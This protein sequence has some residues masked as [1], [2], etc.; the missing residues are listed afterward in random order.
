MRKAFICPTKY[1]QGQDELLNLGYFIK[2]FG[3]SALLIA[4]KDDIERVKDKLDSTA[5]KF[6]VTFVESNFKGECSREEVARLQE[7]AKKNKC[8][9]TIG[10]GGGKA[11]DTAKCV[12]QGNNLIIVPT[13]AATDAPTSHSAVLYTPDGAFDDYAYFKQSPSVVLVDTTVIAKA[14]T[15]FLVSGM[16]DA[17]STYFEA[18]ATASSYSNVNAGLPCGYREGLCGEAKGTNTALAL[19]KLCYETL[20]NDGVKA[21]VSS[22]C[23]LVT[24]ALENIIETN[25]LLSGLGFESGGLAAAHAIHD[26]LTILEGTHK[27]FH[28]EKVAFGTIAQLVLENAPKE[29]IEEVLEFCLQVGLPV[30][31]EDIGVETITEEELKE[32]AEKACIKEES[33]YSMP[34]PINV[35]EVAAA[36]IT[37]DSIGKNYKNR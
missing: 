29:E 6:G 32:V 15:R 35:D 17:L 31:L 37:A 7:L 13:I 3:D 8:A 18:R 4:H 21:K 12:A 26:G 20:I 16:G 36:I 9:C 14:P 10:L 27:Y 33:I 23:N 1:V 28:G 25:I 5:K 24:P 30:C 19:A 2:V 22:D 11:I 34:F